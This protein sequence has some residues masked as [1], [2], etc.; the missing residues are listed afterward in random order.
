MKAHSFL[1]TILLLFFISSVAN[2]QSITITGTIRDSHT[3]EPISYASVYLSAS[4]I[5][6]ISDSSGSFLF[7]LNNLTTDTLVVSYVGYEDFK[8]PVNGLLENMSLDIQLIRGRANADVVVRSSIN[9][10][11]FLWKK[12]MAKKQQYNRYNLANFGYE[13]YN[14]LEIDIKNF[15]ADRVKNNILLKPFSFIT[16]S[17]SEVSDSAGS[18]PAY[19]IESVSDYAYQRNPKKYFENIKASNTRGFINESVSK[20]LGV[21][22]QN[23]NI[24]N[25]YVSVMNKDF[26]GPFH[27]NADSYYFFSVPDTQTV[28]GSKI[29]H[30]VFRP[31]HPG[32]NTFEG[33][34]WVKGGSFEIQKISLFLGKDAN[35][36]YIDRISVFQEF[37]PINDSMIFLN[38]DKFFADFRVLG[39]KSL[40]LTG[41]KTTSY[42]N[43]VT[44]SDSIALLFKTQSGEE[45]ITTA[46]GF[47]Q[48][49]DSAWNTIRHD[50]LSKHEKAIYTTIDNLLH[51]PKYQ[52]LQDNF[53][54]LGSGYKNF[55]NIEVGKWFSLVS[56]NQWEG[57]RFRLDLGTNKG[58]NKNIH[59]HTYLVYGTKDQKFKGR[60]EAFWVI[61][62]TPN[63]FRLHLAY[64]NDIDNDISQNGKI[65]SDNVFSLAIRKP[66]S[67]RKF[68]QTKDLRLEAYKAWGKGFSTE[69]FASQQRNT[70]LL[71]LP[72]K[73]NFPVSNGQ[74]LNNFELALKLR[75]AYME[76]Y[77]DGD[78]FRYSAGSKYPVAELL[79]AK[80]IPGVFNSAYSYTRFSAAISDVMKISPYGTL[81]YKAYA[82]KIYGTLPFTLLENHTGNDLY[83]YNADAFNLM[84]RFE[85]ISD[86]YAGINV[87][88]NIGSGL[89]RFIPVTRKLK[90]RQFWNVKTIWGSLSEKNK[91]LN[92]TTSF[93][94]TLNGKTYMEAGTG[95][96]NIFKIFR[97]DLVWRILP[98]PLPVNKA[99]R[100]GVFGSLQFN[101]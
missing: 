36:N 30:F 51:D 35:I 69:L 21:M 61:K 99:S 94:K 54:F 5:G 84:Y 18:L 24:Y 44:N 77:I 49:T 13:A 93:F 100:F 74:P 101:F 38:R 88:H 95:I 81:A 59:L 57:T 48:T 20:L 31:K 41:R 78:F 14:K 97:F 37:L 52:R 70:P 65:S 12:I 17:L 58:F 16:K 46:P 29:F 23:V 91:A 19:L 55:G 98:S 4:R 27:D 66:N 90:W 40:T 43:I 96:D 42:K 32:Q 68:L 92:N 80:G 79:F 72:L 82:G 87:E 73:E 7:H 9:K 39:K 28:N 63:W 1:I 62:R 15:N 67:T 86:R 76:Q 3:Q 34:A 33:D 8:I 10:G 45:L 60:A 89:F 50:S 53:K 85:Y 47:T 11:L 26:I 2:A 6:K 64:T 83:Y 25:N 75:F 56:G 71:N 22:N